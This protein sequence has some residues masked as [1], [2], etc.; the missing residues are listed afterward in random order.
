MVALAQAPVVVDLELFARAQRPR[1]GYGEFL[2][3]IE[4]ALPVMREKITIPAGR[5]ERKLSAILGRGAWA[6]CR[7]RR[8]HRSP[9]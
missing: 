3:R 1:A 6:P 4:L 8:F 5:K 7:A 9:S 2:A